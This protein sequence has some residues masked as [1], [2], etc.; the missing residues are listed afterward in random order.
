MPCCII[1]LHERVRAG[2]IDSGLKATNAASSGS[3]FYRLHGMEGYSEEVEEEEEEFTRA[4]VTLHEQFW[5]V[6]TPGQKR[7]IDEP[8]PRPP[9]LAV[10]E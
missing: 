1:Q 7:K 10:V 6:P 3:Y 4:D 8:A 5:P 9:P 2:K